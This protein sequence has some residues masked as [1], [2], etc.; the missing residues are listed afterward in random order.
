MLDLSKAKRSLKRY[1]EQ[2]VCVD[3]LLED[4]E[5]VDLP[6]R[7]GASE[8]G[9]H[10]RVDTWEDFKEVILHYKGRVKFN[11][12][13]TIEDDGRRLFWY[14]FLDLDPDMAFWVTLKLSLDPHLVGE[15]QEYIREATVVE[16]TEYKIVKRRKDVT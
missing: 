14:K 12:Q 8:T 15:D 6:G 2:L 13:G 3:E 10:W 16:R 11:G 9:L 5:G 4:L 7:V 1:R